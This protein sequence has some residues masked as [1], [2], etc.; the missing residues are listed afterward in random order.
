MKMCD[1]LVVAQPSTA[2]KEK[3]EWLDGL[4]RVRNC[5]AHRLGRV[6]MVDV[7]PSG[8]S[9]NNT[10][11]TDTLKAVWLRPR[12][13]V[14]GKEVDLPYTTAEATQGTVEFKPYGREWKIGDQIDVSPLDCQA[15]AISLSMLSQQLVA[16]F[17]G[18]MNALL[19]IPTPTHVASGR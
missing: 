14:N 17:E 16:E 9:L 2:L 5:L 15:I 3:M 7:K 11:D 6:Q 12:I 10:Q 8:V 1:G 4:Y 19:G 13:L 18:E